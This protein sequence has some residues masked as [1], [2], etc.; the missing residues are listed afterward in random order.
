MK[1]GAIALV[2][3]LYGV[4]WFGIRGIE[5][6]PTEQEMPA[7]FQLQWVTIDEPSASASTDGGIYFWIRSAGQGESTGKPRAF[8]LPYDDQTADAA[9]EALE[10][11]QDGR[12]VEG[13]MTLQA[14]DPNRENSQEE[15]DRNDDGAPPT[16]GI[17]ERPAFEFREMPPLDL[18]AKPPL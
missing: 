4:T 15:P 14:L 11:L 10:M 2:T 7:R 9:R 17:E 3:L 18:P 13:R 16:L 5:G 8:E 12:R 1:S 6:W